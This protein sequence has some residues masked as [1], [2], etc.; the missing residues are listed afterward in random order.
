MAEFYIL[1][2][3]N[4]FCGAEDLG[5]SKHLTITTLKL[6]VMEEKTAAHHPGGS[7]FEV[8]ISALGFNPLTATFHL[9]GFDPGMLKLFGLG[10]ALRRR[11]T[12]YG[13]IRDKL[14][15]RAIQAKSL[16]DGRLNRM[17]QDAFS[18]GALTGHDY[19]LSEIFHY[20]LYFDGKE[21]HYFDFATVEWRV[22]G[23]SQND[24]RRLLGLVS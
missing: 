11:Y 3:V 17:E 8:T 18:R 21:K 6:P 15:G 1:E 20:E 2:A 10:N 22:D 9:A 14:S 16:I 24:E 12:A 7:L 4:L 5:S 13:V 19:A 23:V